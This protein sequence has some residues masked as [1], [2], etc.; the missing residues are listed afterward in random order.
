MQ[1][2][3]P[4]FMRVF[5]IN[6]WKNGLNSGDSATLIT[7]RPNFQSGQGLKHVLRHVPVVLRFPLI[8]RCADDPIAST[9][10]SSLESRVVQSDPD[11]L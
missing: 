6:L 11:R 2:F 3:S 9:I 7:Q 1:A 4:H 8:T 5:Y 10:T